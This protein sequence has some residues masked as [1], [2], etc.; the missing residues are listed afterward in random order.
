VSPPTER[1]AAPHQGGRGRPEA[2]KANTT[3][4][5]IS[6]ADIFAEAR[7]AYSIADAWRMLRLPG[8]PKQ[9]G[10]MR[11]PFRED[12]NPSFSIFDGG[13]AF[14]DHASGE[15]GDVIEFIRVALGCDH[16]EVREWLQERLGIDYHDGANWH[17]K[18]EPVKAI[19]WPGDL[20]TG[21]ETTWGAFA[22][23]MRMTPLSVWLA[24]Q[25]GILRFT[26]VNGVRCYVITDEARRAAEIRRCDG[27]MFGD[28]KAY[29]LPGVDKSWLPGAD[30]LRGTQKTTSIVI[31][32]G[33]KDMLAAISLYTRYRRAGGKN[34]WCPVA[35]LGA[36]C[37]R[38]HP[39]LVPWFRGRRVRLVPD[40]DTAGDEMAEHWKGLLLELGCTVDVIQ[41]PRGKDLFDLTNEIQP[42]ELFA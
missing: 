34:S 8:E 11:S 31:T 17:Q 23:K 40:G 22:A 32:E 15:G 42:E 19:Q 25:A 27:G 28:T 7:E 37:K 24:V 26:R 39:E 29:K 5:R 16:R 41:M 38:L 36:K 10:C 9:I 21:D 4:S 2:H 35:L 33:P 30:F 18:P 14:K 1:E 6:Q 20:L 3:G 12:N 13:K